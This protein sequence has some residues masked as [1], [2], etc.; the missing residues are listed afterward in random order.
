MGFWRD[1]LLEKSQPSSKGWTSDA[2]AATAQAA[3]ERPMMAAVAINSS[4]RAS[5]T[6]PETA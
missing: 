5:E 1:G 6:R 3:Q 4:S 2:G